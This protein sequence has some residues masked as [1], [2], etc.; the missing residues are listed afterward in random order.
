MGSG[1]I[2][3]SAVGLNNLEPWLEKKNHISMADGWTIQ[4]KMKLRLSCNLGEKWNI[5]LYPWSSFH[6]ELELG[7][8]RTM[9]PSL[10]PVDTVR[11]QIGPALLD[12]PFLVADRNF[13]VWWTL[14]LEH[15]R[16]ADSHFHKLY[17]AC[18]V[19]PKKGMYRL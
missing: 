13:R 1:C 19:S 6:R 11:V 10:R 7:V 12:G 3:Y 4:W 5:I 15:H 18:R 14:G 16:V 2:F 17:N 9:Q 8:A